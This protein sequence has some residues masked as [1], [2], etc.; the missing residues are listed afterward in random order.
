MPD[1]PD[2][3]PSFAD[4]VA[5]VEADATCP[6]CGVDVEVAVDPGGGSTQEYVEDCPICCRPWAVTVAYDR[7]GRASVTLRPQDGH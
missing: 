3:R 7:V 4:G 6:W 1:S 2:R 5:D